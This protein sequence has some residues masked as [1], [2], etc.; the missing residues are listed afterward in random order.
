MTIGSALILITGIITQGMPEISLTSWGIIAWLAVV[1]S[2]FAYTLWNGILKVLPAAE[3]SIL[4]NTMMVQIPIL[5]VLFLGETI[6][7][8][9]LIGMGVVIIGTLLV[10]WQR[11]KRT[12]SV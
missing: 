2:A 7:S 6:T 11:R 5:A 10:Q 8:R 1:N 12:S 3:A 9:Q 4:N